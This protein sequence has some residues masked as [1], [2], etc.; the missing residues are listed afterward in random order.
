MLIPGVNKLTVVLDLAPAQYMDMVLKLVCTH[1]HT[2]RPQ[3]PSDP[4]RAW[5][6]WNPDAISFQDWCD[7]YVVSGYL[8]C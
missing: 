7:T 3:C 4:A 2:L 6:V 8:R 5:K 1:T